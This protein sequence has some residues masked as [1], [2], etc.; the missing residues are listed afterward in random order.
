MQSRLNAHLVI[1]DPQNDFMGEDGLDPNGFPIP[2]SVKVGNDEMKAALPVPGAVPDM[3][4]LATMLDRVGDRIR[5]DGIHVTLDSHQVMHI[6]NPGM[7]R[8]SNGN[9]PQPFTIIT[10]DDIENGIWSPAL[11]QDRQRVLDYVHKLADQGNYPLLIWPEHCI[12]GSWG[13]N[14]Q[15]D[16]AAALSR[17]CRKRI[18]N[19]DWVAKGTD[20]YTEHYGALMAEVPDPTQPRTQLNR[21]FLEI[22]QVADIIGVAGEASSHCVRETVNQ[23][24][25]HIGDEHLKK[26]YLIEDCMSPVQAP[27]GVPDFPAITKQFFAQMEQRGMNVTNSTDFLN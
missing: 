25:T 19:I 9:M 16:L 17:W 6:A 20:A 15:P 18:A 27:G 8:D 12:I 22:L 5:R 24:A 26:F 10:P 3:K 23:I 2:Y 7:W 1:I 14:V 11:P 21:R 13:H 4:R